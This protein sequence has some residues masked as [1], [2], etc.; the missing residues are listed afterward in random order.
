M[1]TPERLTDAANL[2]VELIDERL[3]NIRREETLLLK[4]RKALQPFSG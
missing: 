2:T 3:Y 1:E 4:A